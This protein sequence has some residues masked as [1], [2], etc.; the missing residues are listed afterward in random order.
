M[1][2]KKLAKAT[3]ADLQNMLAEKREELR[4]LRFK[5]AAN[6]LK[7]VHKIRIVR[8]DIAQIMTRLNELK[9]QEA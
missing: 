5:V 6:Q 7:Q 3:A 4:E 1:E 9:K 8:T 2:Y